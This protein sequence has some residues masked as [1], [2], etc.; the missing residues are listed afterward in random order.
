MIKKNKVK[1]AHKR[2]ERAKKVYGITE[3]KTDSMFLRLAASPYT[4]PIVL[5]I[6]GAILLLFVAK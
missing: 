2:I 1:S 5:L 6:C 3:V 4:L